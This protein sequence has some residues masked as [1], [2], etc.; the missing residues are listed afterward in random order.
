LSTETPDE[1]ATASLNTYGYSPIP[2]REY[3]RYVTTIDKSIQ[4]EIAR[5]STASQNALDARENE[6]RK[7]IIIS[8]SGT[9]EEVGKCYRLITEHAKSVKIPLGMEVNLSCPNIPFEPPPAYL[10]S[11]L[12]TY[13]AVLKKESSVALARLKAAQRQT[14]GSNDESAKTP[15]PVAIAVGI[16]IPPYT[17][18]DQ[19]TTLIHSLL[20]TITDGTPCPISFIT[21]TNTLGNS[22]VYSTS[23]L[24]VL[25]S[26]DGSG[27]G[28]LAGDPLHPLALGNVCTLRKRL[29][30]HPELARIRIIGVGGV[31]DNDGYLRMIAAG[32]EAVGVATALGRRGVNV[33]EEISNGL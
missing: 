8:V 28:G 18:A 16:K 33:F 23:C 17:Y 25:K 27:I 32:A 1:E 26:S 10:A 2:L 14:S 9:A 11:G 12:A 30:A 5:G 22:L 29:S 15:E 3:L 13:L 24:P 4:K 7:P 20:A 19:F 6:P 21:A 31:K